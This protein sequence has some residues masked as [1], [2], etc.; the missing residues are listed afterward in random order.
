MKRGGQI[1][2]GRGRVNR[3]TDK[4]TVG[5]REGGTDRRSIDIS[6][7]VGVHR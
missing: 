7:G 1:E 3:W 6:Y 4:R 2:S 5:D